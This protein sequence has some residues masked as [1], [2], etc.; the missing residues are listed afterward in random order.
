MNMWRL[1]SS[2]FHMDLI[3]GN[4]LNSKEKKARKNLIQIQIQKHQV[5][6]HYQYHHIGRNR[7]RLSQLEKDNI[8]TYDLVALKGN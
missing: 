1:L 5:Q 8:I 2:I 4:G 3:R 6:G 7:D